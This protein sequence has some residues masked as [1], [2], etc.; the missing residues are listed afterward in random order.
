MTR[1]QNSVISIVAI[2]RTNK[3]SRNESISKVEHSYDF[4]TILHITAKNIKIR[5]CNLQHA[6]FGLLFW[7]TVYIHWL[8]FNLQPNITYWL[9]KIAGA[10]R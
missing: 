5:P 2:S 3:V 1:R 4:K 10:L 6:T 7:N 9:K 8:C